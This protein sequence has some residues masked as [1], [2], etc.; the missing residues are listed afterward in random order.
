VYNTGPETKP[1]PKNPEQLRTIVRTY[2][3]EDLLLGAEQE[4]YDNES[5]VDSGILDSTGAIEL[6][7]FLENTFGIKM[8]DHEIGP[9]NLETIT[10]ICNF[11][12]Y[13]TPDASVV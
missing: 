4:L 5:L 8:E 2:I 3:S 11:I 12:I 13:K 10:R 6:V 9:E 1:I 7:A